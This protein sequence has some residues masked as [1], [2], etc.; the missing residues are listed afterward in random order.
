MSRKWSE[1]EV[2]TSD[3]TFPRARHA[4]TL[5]ARYP[6]DPRSCRSISGCDDTPAQK[7]VVA[8]I[9]RIMEGIRMEVV[10]PPHDHHHCPGESQYCL[11]QVGIGKTWSN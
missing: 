8:P 7:D 4:K 6:P 2:Q 9:S 10:L 5:A 11:H 1:S 3:R